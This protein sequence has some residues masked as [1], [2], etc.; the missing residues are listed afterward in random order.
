M[1]LG[2]TPGATP[3]ILGA[4]TNQGSVVFTSSPSGSQSGGQ[5]SGRR[6]KRASPK[7]PSIQVLHLPH[8]SAPWTS[9]VCC[10]RVSPL[11]LARP[12]TRH[13]LCASESNPSFQGV[14]YSRAF[15]SLGAQG[16]LFHSSLFPRT[17][18]EWP[19]MAHS[20]SLLMH[21]QPWLLLT[22]QLHWRHALSTNRWLSL[23]ELQS[24]PLIESLWRNAQAFNQICIFLNP[25]YSLGSCLLTHTH[26]SRT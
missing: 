2:T 3:Y 19:D 4:Q 13:R 14:F 16:I 22:F 5:P 21:R 20:G 23:R 24:L 1:Y 8:L 25:K 26:N 9:T 6:W 15:R 11:M 7:A 18:Q 17:E 12:P 10:C